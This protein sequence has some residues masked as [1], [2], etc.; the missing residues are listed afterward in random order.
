MDDLSGL[1]AGP[2]EGVVIKDESLLRGYRLRWGL[3]NPFSGA[4]DQLLMPRVL[5]EV[6]SFLWVG[7][8]VIKFPFST[9]IMNGPMVK[10]PH[11]NMARLF[12]GKGW[13][14]ADFR[15]VRKPWNKADAV[16]IADRREMA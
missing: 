15:R 13:A 3:W 1:F 16:K 14:L 11:R 10:S 12:D 2:C 7:S 5:C 4:F 6:G 8:M 9:R